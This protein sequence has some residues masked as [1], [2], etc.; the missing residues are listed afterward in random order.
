MSLSP[1]E[2]TLRARIGAHTLHATHD[3]TALT[4]PA[5]AAARDAL[6]E[7]LLADIDPE[8]SLSSDERARRLGH[9]RSAH[10]ARLALKS[11][12]T[13]RVRRERRAK[14]HA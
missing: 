11:A 12:K 9:A 13:R 6:D 1:A 5:R 10:F 7:R 8:S 3:S 2:R 14:V 4:A